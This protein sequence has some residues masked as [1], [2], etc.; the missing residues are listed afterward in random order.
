MMS[1]ADHL[2]RA[3]TIGVPEMDRQ[4]QTMLDVLLHLRQDW[5]EALFIRLTNLVD[6]HF[7]DEEAMAQQ[8]GINNVEH[9]HEHRTLRQAL[10]SLGR[11][12]ELDGAQRVQAILSWFLLHVNGADRELGAA[13][14]RSGM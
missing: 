12:T 2:M 10:N 5:D 7:A 13:I 4:H 6:Q 1:E 11:S 3:Y 9:Q 14:L 8:H